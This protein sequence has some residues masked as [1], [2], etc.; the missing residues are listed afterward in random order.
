[1]SRWYYD[2]SSISQ[3][4]AENIDEV[5]EQMKYVAHPIDDT[6]RVCQ[7][8]TLHT[9]GSRVFLF[10]GTGELSRQNSVH[11][12]VT[13]GGTATSNTPHSRLPN[14]AK[15]CAALSPD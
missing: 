2:T 4:N 6:H 15:L 7:C 1:M 13:Q 9:L 3:D 12:T 14:C 8:D 5:S 11:T 10:R